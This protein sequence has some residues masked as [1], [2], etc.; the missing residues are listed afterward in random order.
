MG[1]NPKNAIPKEDKKV[2]KKIN[3]GVNELMINDIKVVKAKNTE[4]V[5]LEY[6]VEGRPVTEEGFEGIDAINHLAGNFLVQ[7]Q[8]ATASVFAYATATHYKES[9][10]NGKT[11]EYVGTYNL[12]LMKHGVGWRIYEFKYNLKYITGNVDF[13]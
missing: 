8:D 13:K 7:V 5:K 3:Y 6:M 9:A 10:S 4:S 1:L 2:G 11:R 12:N